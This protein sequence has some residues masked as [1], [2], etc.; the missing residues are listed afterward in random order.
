M[1]LPGPQRQAQGFDDLGYRYEFDVFSPADHFTLALNDQYAPAAEFLGDARGQARPGARDVR[2]QP[3]DG[4][5]RARH[6]GGPRLLAVGRRRCARAAA[7]RRWARSTRSRAGS[8]RPTRRRCRPSAARGSLDGG[9]LG[10]IAFTSQRREWGPAPAKTGA[11]ALVVKARN[12]GTRDRAPRRA[13]GVSCAATLSVDTDGPRARSSSPAAGAARRSPPPARSPARGA[14]ARTAGFRRAR[15]R[16]RG[17]GLRVAFSRTVR[18]RV[19]VDVLRHSRGRRA[20]G[21]RARQ[22]VRAARAVVHVARPRRGPRRLHGA[23][24]DAA[25]GRAHRRAP[26]RGRAPRRAVR[27]PPGLGAAAGLPGSPSGSARRCSAARPGGSC[28]SPTGS[29]APRACG[30]SVVRGGKVVRRLGRAVPP[31]ARTRKLRPR[32]LR[33]GLPRPPDD[34][35]RGRAAAPFTLTARRL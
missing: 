19:T 17:R 34:P 21:A 2:A 16:P 15:V 35:P 7:T 18:R 6:H 32:A 11:D 4:L 13:R 30:P 31:A 24:A 10:S 1:P 3:D 22:A 25:R 5:R 12:V 20:I 23:P 29:R 14:C 9:A 27:P 26:L 28:A 8:R 33:R